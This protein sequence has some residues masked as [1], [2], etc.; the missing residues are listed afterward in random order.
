M[1][2]LSALVA[3]LSLMKSVAPSAA[4]LLQ[5]MRQAGKGRERG[6]HLAPARRRGCMAAALAAS[7]FWMLCWPR[8]EPMPARS[9]KGPS[10]PVHGAWLIE[11]AA[12]GVPAVRD[13]R[14]RR[15]DVDPASVG[16]P[17]AL[18]DIAAPVVV[19]ADDRVLAPPAPAAP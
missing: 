8:S 9:A 12:V 2:A 5:A 19:I 13:A 4:D 14:A 11:L 16:E 18:G 17:Q 7:A 10:G 15:D 3:L 6:G 1:A